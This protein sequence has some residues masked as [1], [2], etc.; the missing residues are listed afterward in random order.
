MKRSISKSQYIKGIQCPKQLWLYLNRKDLAPEID[1][2]TQALFDQGHLVGEYAKEYFKGGSEVTAPYYKVDEAIKL[3]EGFIQDGCKV[4]YEACA[5]SP[6]GIY[7]KID[8]LR[9]VKGQKKW[10]LIEVKSSTSVKA[11][12]I[13]M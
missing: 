10:D 1:S 11:L 6:D 12:R 2:G 8:I 9:K 3:T 7:S 13:P 5:M 4:I